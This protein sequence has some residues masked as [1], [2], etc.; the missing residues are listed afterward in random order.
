MQSVYLLLALLFGFIVGMWV[1]GAGVDVSDA[2][3]ALATLVA[4]FAG[5]SFAFRLNESRE[6]KKERGTNIAALNRAL[7]ILARQLN[8]IQNMKNELAAYKADIE[9]AFNLPAGKLPEY[10]DLRQHF[11]SLSFLLESEEPTVLMELTVE[12]ECFEQTMEAI[13]LRNHFHVTEVQPVI[14]AAGLNHKSV[15]RE[16]LR[17]ALGERLFE[18]SISGA[19]H[20]YEHVDASAESLVKMQEKIFALAKR[21]FPKE[22]FTKWG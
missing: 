19:K 9:R 10:A 13:R 21:L 8:A 5:S 3:T 22:Q 1:C 7:F 14:A 15:S 6:R 2:I 20:I 11:E 12:Q 17:A 18:G 16:Q 4:A